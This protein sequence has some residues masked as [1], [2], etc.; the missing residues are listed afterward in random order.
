MTRGINVGL[1]LTADISYEALSVFAL[2]CV[3]VKALSVPGVERT[4]HS[5]QFTV[6]SLTS[7]LLFGWVSLYL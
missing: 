7:V 3:S 2:M 5:I 4:P 1:V 6:L